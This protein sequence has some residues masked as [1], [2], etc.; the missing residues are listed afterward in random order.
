M[1]DH[2]NLDIQIENRTLVVH[3]GTIKNKNTM[4]HCGNANLNFFV[5]N[6]LPVF[7]PGVTDCIFFTFRSDKFLFKVETMLM[8]WLTRIIII[9]QVVVL[10]VEIIVVVVIVVIGLLV[11][12][13]V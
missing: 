8:Y 4:T 3:A 5:C 2:K 1:K 9:L 11:V 6:P 13:V 10:V 7:N 12:I